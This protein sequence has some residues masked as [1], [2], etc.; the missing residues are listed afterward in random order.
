M[1]Q[2]G[3]I[4]RA[5][6]VSAVTVGGLHND[7]IGMRKIYRVTQDGLVGVADIPG[8]NELCLRLPLGYPQLYTGRTKQMSYISKAQLDAGCN[9][10]PPV[11]IQRGK[12]LQRSFCILQC[13]LRFHRRVAGALGLAVFPLGLG[14]LN[15][16]GVAQHN[17][18]EPVCRLGRIYFAAKALL[19]K[20][21][22]AACMIDMGMGDEYTVDLSG[23]NG[24]RLVFVHI[25]ALLHTAVYEIPAARSLQQRT[26][27][28]HLMVCAQKGQFHLACTSILPSAADFLN[29]LYHKIVNNNYIGHK[30]L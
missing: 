5:R 18:T 23:G 14:F 4:I 7:I 1:A 9:L 2:L 24:Q 30:I 26:A 16:G 27:A 11:V 28:R 6:A 20:Q 29:Q 19:D 15:M 10:I 22:Q 25:L 13:V 21:G 3:N 8:K 12:Q 17:V